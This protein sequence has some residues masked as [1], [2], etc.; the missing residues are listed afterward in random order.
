MAAVLLHVVTLVTLLISMLTTPTTGQGTAADTKQTGA[1][2]RRE[3][4]RRAHTWTSMAMGTA[5]A[6][7]LT[8]GLTRPLSN[9]TESLSATL[10]L[11]AIRLEH[12]RHYSIPPAVQGVVVSPATSAEGVALVVRPGVEAAAAAGGR[13]AETA[14]AT[15]NLNTGTGP[16]LGT[17]AAASATENGATVN[18]RI[19]EPV[20]HHLRREE[21]G[22]PAAEEISETHR[23]ASMRNVLDE[24]PGMAHRRQ[25]L[26]HRTPFS[27][28]RPSGA[29]P[30]GSLAV[31]EEEAVVGATIGI[32][33]VGEEEAYST[34]NGTAIR[35]QEV[36]LRKGGGDATRMTG[37]VGMSDTLTWPEI[38]AMNVN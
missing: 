2:V 23:S 37:N 35:V 16:I 33:V 13:I 38:L 18:V 24:G 11:D 5:A 31:P 27:P 7:L 10:S 26:R 32:A 19:S 15:V 36:A 1:R 17:N 28:P 25:A 29:V 3:T 20:G 12:L 34:M 30:A 9:P 22:H 21:V 8:R 4:G 14:D 6:S